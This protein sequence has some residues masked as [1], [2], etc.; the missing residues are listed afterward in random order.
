MKF[1]LFPDDPKPVGPE[2]WR[3]IAWPAIRRSVAWYFYVGLA[4]AVLMPAAWVSQSSTIQSV[5][6]SVASAVPAVSRFVAISDFPEVTGC[7][8][9]MMWLLLPIPTLLVALRWPPLPDAT[10][11]QTISLLVLSTAV[12]ATTP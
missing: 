5:I 3:K 2:S 9:A 6:E 10:F 11:K 8:F 12:P 7:Y 4:V 1:K